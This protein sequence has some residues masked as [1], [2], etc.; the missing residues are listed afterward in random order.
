MSSFNNWDISKTIIKS[1]FKYVI[2]IESYTN[3]NY[4]L[5]IK[6]MYEER[7]RIMV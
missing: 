4:I 2:K 6:W 5:E 7:K 1:K 3:V